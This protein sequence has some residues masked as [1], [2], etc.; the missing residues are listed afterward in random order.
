[1]SVCLCAS[2]CVCVSTC[3][4]VCTSPC[5]C[6]R[7]FLCV[8]LFFVCECSL[9]CV[10]VCVCVPCCCVIHVHAKKIGTS[11]LAYVCGFLLVSLCCG[12]SS[13]LRFR[14]GICVGF[15]QSPFLGAGSFNVCGFS[16]SLFGSR[17]YR[18]LIKVG[19]GR[20]HGA[21]AKQSLFL[22][23]TRWLASR[24]LGHRCRTIR[25]WLCRMKNSVTVRPCGEGTRSQAQRN[26]KVRTCM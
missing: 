12:W 18:A 21:T 7:V 14:F 23:R 24:A 25:C 19:F 3:V 17:W 2:L 26:V 5:A 9:L 15:V 1:M 8:C 16:V 11:T 13:V 10:C 20:C 4:F 6:L 22:L